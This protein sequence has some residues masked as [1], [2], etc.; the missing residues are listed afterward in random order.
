MG[1]DEDIFLKSTSIRCYSSHAL[2]LGSNKHAFPI[3]TN[4]WN[5][6]LVELSLSAQP[7]RAPSQGSSIAALLIVDSSSFEYQ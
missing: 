3:P 7:I 4:V 6:V 2:R 1:G 5:F